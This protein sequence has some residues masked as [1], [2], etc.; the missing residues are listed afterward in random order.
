MLKRLQHRFI[1]IT[2][3]AVAIVV[4]AQ[5]LAVNVINIAQR[6]AECR[7][8][9]TVIMNSD[10]PKEGEGYGADDYFRAFFNPFGTRR[11]TAETPYSTKYFVITVENNVITGI[12]K[13]NVDD[14]T[15]DELISLAS[16]VYKNG[17]GFDFSGNYRTYTQTN[18]NGVTTIAF[19][20][21][22]RELLDTMK[23]AGITL[24]VGL[25][26][27]VIL[28]I[29]V[30]F[31]AKR[32]IKPVERSIEKQKQF[33]TDASHELKTPIAI[34]SAN[35][36]VLEMIEGENE[37]VESIKNQTVRLNTLVKNLVTLSKLEETRNTPT[38]EH[39]NLS[40]SVIDVATPFVT[41]ANNK[42]VEFSL[43]VQDNIMMDASESEIRQLV[44]ILCDNA[45][46]YVTPGG[47]IKLTVQKKG[48]NIYLDIFND[49]EDIDPAKLE[50]LFDR[51]YRTDTSRNSTTGGHGI[52][53]SI[54]Q[55]VVERNHGKIT[56]VSTKPNTVTFKVR[57]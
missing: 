27:I 3:F 53:L 55:V 4:F 36:E 52:G 26:L 25:I 48:R 47:E 13:K 32:A 45:V 46:K 35:A 22:Q 50:K 14:L 1:R 20:D 24:I 15:E 10:E 11:F 16:T 51:F 57:F 2:F 5:L 7:E 49:C 6:D 28:I 42:G 56:A 23:L 31:Y 17:D 43:D 33:I 34:I 21:Y 41:P 40:D 9:L 12:T 37:W 54:A 38:V 18:S 29:P 8:I 39:F 30:I 19:L 44:S